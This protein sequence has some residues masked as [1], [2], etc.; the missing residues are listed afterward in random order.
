MAD[1]SKKRRRSGRLGAEIGVSES[2]IDT[3]SSDVLPHLRLGCDGE[4]WPSSAGVCARVSSVVA[5]IAGCMVRGLNEGTEFLYTRLLLAVQRVLACVCFGRTSCR[6]TTVH[7]R[8]NRSCIKSSRRPARDPRTWHAALRF[9]CL[10]Y[11]GTSRLPM[12]KCIIPHWSTGS[13]AC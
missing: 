11:R 5:I 3:V 13:R 10:L 2:S 8:N 7:E 6:E 9:G 12:R 1:Q 4:S